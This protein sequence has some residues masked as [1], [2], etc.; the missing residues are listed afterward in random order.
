MFPETERMTGHTDF[1]ISLRDS[2][3]YSVPNLHQQY[4]KKYISISFIHEAHTER[5]T[6]AIV[7]AGEHSQ[8]CLVTLM[9]I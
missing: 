7:K 1:K 9:Q 3:P 4:Q 5:S 2:V 8:V 6:F